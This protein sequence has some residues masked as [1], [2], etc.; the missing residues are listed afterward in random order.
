[1]K[2]RGIIPAL[3]PLHS[4]SKKDDSFFAANLNS[5]FK[6]LNLKNLNS[7]QK[8]ILEQLTLLD[9]FEKK[10]RINAK[11]IPEAFGFSESLDEEIK[12]KLD[13]IA[14]TKAQNNQL[15]VSFLLSGASISSSVSP[16]LN[17]NSFQ[18]QLDKYT[19]IRVCEEGINTVGIVS[20]N[21]YIPDLNGESKNKSKGFSVHLSKDI[22]L[23]GDLLGEV[24]K[25]QSTQAAFEVVEK[26]RGLA[27]EL[28]FDSKQDLKPEMMEVIHK[29]DLNTVADVVKAFTIYFHLV[30]EAEKIE[31]VRVNRQR[32]IEATDKPRKESLAEAVFKVKEQGISPEKVQEILSNLNIQPVFT[33]H[34]TEAKSPEILNKLNTIALLISTKSQGTLAETEENKLRGKIKDEIRMLWRTPQIRESK[35]TV[36]EEAENSLFFLSESAF[37][38]VPELNDD[39]CN[40]LKKYYPSYDFNIPQ[41]IKFGSWVGGDRDGN[42]N[43]TD[44][45][46]SAVVK[47]N[48]VEILS[49]YIE[50]V[51]KLSQKLTVPDASSELKA[52]VKKDERLF[53]GFSVGD[54]EP[55][56]Q[57]LWIIESKLVQTRA[58]LV[59][60]HPRPISSYKNS[61]EFLND[62]EI[63]A[64]SLR[65]KN[66]PDNSVKKLIIQIKTFGFHFAELDVRQHSAVHEKAV[67]EILKSQS[68]QYETLDEKQK[69]ELLTKLIQDKDTSLR[70]GTVLSEQS[71]QVLDSFHTIKDLH[72]NIGRESVRCYVVSFTNSVS[73]LLEVAF[74]GKQAGLLKVNGEDIS[75]EL[76]FVPLFE[77]VNDLQNSHK[78]LGELFDNS[79]YKKILESRN[80][81]QEVM[82]GYSDGG[83]DGGYLAS[84]IELYKAQSNIAKVCASKDIKFR[85]FHGRGGSIGRGGA[86]AGKA[87]QA[88]PHGSV[89]G[90]IRFTEQGEVIS[91]RYSIPSLAHRHLEAVVHAVLLASTGLPIDTESSDSE[92]M[93][94]LNSLA[95]ISKNKY[96]DLVYNDPDFWNFYF[97]VTPYRFT[98]T[99]NIASRPVSRSGKNSVEDI[100]A[101][102]W[103]FSLTQSRLMLNSWYGVGEAL[104]KAE[105]S[106]GIELL[107]KMYRDWPFFKVTV[108]N[109]QMALAKADRYASS[110][111]IPLVKSEGL[112]DRLS[113]LIYKEEETTKDMI[114]K[115]SGQENI[116]DNAKVLQKS[117]ELRNP[118]TDPLNCIQVEMIKRFE[119]SQDKA[120]KEKILQVIH[121]TMNGIAAAM[122]ETG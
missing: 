66:L 18:M 82:L 65:E 85:F 4:I 56:R 80:K 64:R 41:F 89:N 122:Q 44:M 78:L 38:L 99:W 117:I 119:I 31:I 107:Q 104:E 77:T 12:G 14:V 105:K 60:N 96:R 91:S 69:Q 54:N 67:S 20:P 95:D 97:Q 49:R 9:P 70:Q 73:D 55:Y 92:C 83:K 86:Q 28:R 121:L 43:V 17:V 102:P 63:I 5:L 33:A 22:H 3:T 36:L 103:A 84:N 46:T 40:A 75:S 87:I 68:V 32:E 11:F 115:V 10:I 7:Q 8:T 79:A 42:P 88:Q 37:S 71:R 81:L 6:I 61:L 108:N 101:I 29:L 26:L 112:R 13:G 110:L 111:Y 90:K 39:L 109:C 114:L 76:D 25:E 98:E 47:R 1:M 113:T 59:H 15:N 48:S 19:D 52:S 34:P 72:K 120:E 50:E 106:G 35:P 16:V 51:K 118:Y 53:P 116:L 27:K 62:I 93:K 24:I 2:T 21:L 100:R 74:L 45:V 30:N 58:S 23:L 94:L 57:K